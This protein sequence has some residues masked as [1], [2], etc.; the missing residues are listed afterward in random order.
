MAVL[1]GFWDTVLSDQDGF[2]R[3]FSR[4]ARL[5]GGGR[6]NH[7]TDA[8]LRRAIVA[9]VLTVIPIALYLVQG[10]PVALLKLAGAIEAAHIPVVAGLTLHLNRRVL[11]ATSSRP[12]PR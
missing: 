7:F 2:A 6:A 4:A 10:E 9:V 11:P 8:S 3:M 1:I 12:R 5:L